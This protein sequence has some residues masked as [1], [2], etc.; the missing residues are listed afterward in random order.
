MSET[1]KLSPPAW[2]RPGKPGRKIVRHSLTTLA[3]CIAEIA[4]TYR[5]YK[6][7]KLDAEKARTRVYMLDKLRAGLEA[8]ALGELQQRL[9]E[10]E[11][12]AGG[13]RGL[14]VGSEPLLLPAH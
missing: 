1:A 10:L 4:R 3:G 6:G 7:G 14:G 11:T 12:R 9:G 5:A 2:H 8:E 13:S